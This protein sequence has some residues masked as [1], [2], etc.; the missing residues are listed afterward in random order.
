M[1]WPLISASLIVAII[2]GTFAAF[3]ILKDRDEAIARAAERTSSISRMIIAHGD[4]S[5]GIADQIVNV[6]M[7][8]V[9]AWDLKDTTLGAELSIRLKQL[10]GNNSH[11]ASAAILDAEGTVLVT[12]RDYP[13]QPLNIADRPFH[14]AHAAGAADPLIVGD[15]VAGPIS[16]R[17][18]FTFSRANRNTDGSLRAVVVV[19]IYTSSMDVLYAEAANWP[20]ARAGLYGPNADVLAQAQTASLASLEFRKEIEQI[21]T[22]SLSDS[23]T[24]ITHS[25]PEPR[26]V[27]WNRSKTYAGIYSASSQTM[28]EALKAWRS[29]AVMTGILVGVAN[30]IF[31]G[32][33][34]YAARNAEARQ[35]A[36]SHE[37]AVREIHHRLKNSLQMISSLIRMRSAKFTD[38]ALKEVV[39]EITNDLKAVAEVNSL[40]QAASTLGTVDIAQTVKT[41]CEYLRRTYHAEIDFKSAGP[42]V[43]NANHATA[44]SVIVN[45]LVTNA[46]KHGGGRVDVNCWNTADTLHIEVSNGGAKLAEGFDVE[47]AQGFGLRAVRA[48]VSGFDGKIIAENLEHGGALFAVAVPMSVLLRK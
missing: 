34:F 48:M 33:A 39:N 44:L 31:W 16:G 14:K 15:K 11:V 29:R 30:I 9:A 13:P 28:D 5:A 18:R 6:A 8:L 32:F 35:A 7:P 19:A 42:I 1:R 27:S 40:V 37:L 4:A 20:G 43:I 23:G 21:A 12:S 47:E 38:P 3:V 10:V 17:K 24:T 22:T 36:R 2:T 26:I 41:L 25:E 45:E 46:I